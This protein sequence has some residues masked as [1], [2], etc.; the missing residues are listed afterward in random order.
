[1]SAKQEQ[2]KVRETETQKRDLLKRA[3]PYVYEKIMKYDEKVKRGESIAILQF[4]Y[5]Y[6]CNFHCQHCD[7]TRLRTKNKKRFFTISDVKELSR[8]AD[9]MGLA[10]IVITGGEPLVFP[11]FD[12]IVQ[13]IDPQKFYITSDTNGWLLDEK[14]ARHLKSIG[15]DKIQLSLDSLSASDHDDFRRKKGS[16]DRAI[17]AIDAAI[18]AGLNIIIQTVVTKQRVR[19]S[20]FIEFLEFLNRKGVG[21]FVTYAKPVGDWEGN[22]DILVNRED[23]D[24]I[25]ELE[26]KYNV[27]THLTPG[28]GLDLGC[29]S[30]KRMVSITKYGDVMPCPYIH[31]SLGN[32]FDEP[33]RDII[34]RGLKIKYFG[35]Y[36][37]TCLIAE[38]RK[39]INKYVA[40]RIY[41]KPLPVPYSEVFTDEDFID[42]KKHHA[43]DLS[44]DGLLKWSR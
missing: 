39:F 1:M 18:I 26:K 37:D 35:K 22:F 33:L 43:D 11:D 40:K 42:E 31:V 28:Y 29:I 34:E 5:D 32:F 44:A 2:L 6:K 3:K 41:G 20:E 24:Y 19:S 23:M 30:V 10:H 17:R 36:V 25:R 12:D 21:V 4:Q 14:K 27:F 16:H 38:D 7:I 9:E 15:V 13:A 8:Q